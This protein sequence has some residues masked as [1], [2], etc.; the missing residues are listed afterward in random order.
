[1][2]KQIKSLE[3]YRFNTFSDND[4]DESVEVEGYLIS[5][6]M[7][8]KNG[9]TIET[10]SF[11]SDEEVEEHIQFKYND[12]NLKTEEI[13]F[14]ENEIAERHEFF[15]NDKKQITKELIY[16]Q[17]DMFD[18]MIF[19]YDQDKIVKRTLT[20]SDD[21]VESITIYKYDK[22]N[23]INECKYDADKTILAE[24]KYVFNDAGLLVK[25]EF[26]DIETEDKNATEYEYDERGN[27]T[28]TLALDKSGKLVERY[29]Y[30]YDNKNN[31]ITLL[32]EGIGKYA[33][34]TIE[35][36]EEGNAMK[37]EETDEEGEVVSTITNTYLDGN[38]VEVQSFG[39]EYHHNRMYKYE[40]EF[41][42]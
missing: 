21:E 2:K 25:T 34:F 30:T 7:F 12:E 15:Y 24:K 18:T 36:D 28:K 37:Q 1:M 19:E 35:Y 26:Y 9:N 13:L 20:D 16:Y 8:D 29:T 32:E 17:D 6:L 42:E 27:K 11:D 41:F 40:Y 5:K 3:K 4:T 14:N 10:K 38:I 23:L 31:M 33:F 22:E 39:R